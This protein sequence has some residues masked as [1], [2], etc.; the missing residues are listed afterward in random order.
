MQE[1]Q[2]LFLEKIY[3][4]HCAEKKISE[5]YSATMNFAKKID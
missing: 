3:D 1:W 5:V 2:I 4:V